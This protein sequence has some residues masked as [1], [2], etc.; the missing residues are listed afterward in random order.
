MAS[1]TKKVLSTRTAILNVVNNYLNCARGI[2]DLEK[3][4]DYDD[5]ED[6]IDAIIERIIKENGNA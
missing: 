4:E 3:E 2:L 5:L 6:A 1:K